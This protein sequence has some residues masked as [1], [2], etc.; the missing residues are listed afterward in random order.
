MTIIIGIIF[1]GLFGYILWKAFSGNNEKQ[2][3]VL[4]PSEYLNGDEYETE[5]LS[6]DLMILRLVY[7]RRSNEYD[8]TSSSTEYLLRI[9][10]NEQIWMKMFSHKMLDNMTNQLETYTPEEYIKGY[11]ANILYIESTKINER[12]S[13]GL[14]KFRRKFKP[15]MLDE[16]T[17]EEYEHSLEDVG[18]WKPI[19]PEWKVTVIKWIRECENYFNDKGKKWIPIETH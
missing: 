12:D 2:Y 1:G 13:K 8:G 5:T 6:A 18:E 15:K 10:E 7:E 19:G 9:N 11:Y 4:N 14:D 3:D 16:S 17:R